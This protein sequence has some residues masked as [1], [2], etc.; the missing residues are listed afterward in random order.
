V[1]GT[2]RVRHFGSYP[3]IENNSVRSR[4]STLTAA[5]VGYRL[6]SGVMLQASVLNLLNDR[7][8]DIQYYYASRL[9]GEPLGG[10]DDVHF[11]PVEPRQVRLSLEWKF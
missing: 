1:S 8:D 11:H 3:L 4:A 5:D 7:A 2:L 9:E 6:K 10:T